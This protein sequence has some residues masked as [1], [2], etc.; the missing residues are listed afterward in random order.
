MPVPESSESSKTALPE[1]A[2]IAEQVHRFGGGVY[3]RHAGFPPNVLGAAWIS[4]RAVALGGSGLPLLDSLLQRWSVSGRQTSSLP[5]LE[6]RRRFA[7]HR[8]NTLALSR[9][10][11]KAHRPEIKHDAASDVRIS[12]STVGANAAISPAA[13]PEPA[14]ADRALEPA[15]GPQGEV[16]TAPSGGEAKTMAAPEMDSSDSGPIARKSE[17]SISRAVAAAPESIGPDTPEG[18]PVHRAADVADAGINAAAADHHMPAQASHELPARREKVKPSEPSTAQMGPPI[19][20]RI[21]TTGQSAALSRD[22]V[23]AIPGRRLLPVQK[24]LPQ[25]SAAPAG[26]AQSSAAPAIEKAS[27]GNP[28]RAVEQQDV[29]RAVSANLEGAPAVAARAVPALRVSRLACAPDITRTKESGVQPPGTAGKMLHRLDQGLTARDEGQSSRMPEQHLAT[30]NLTSTRPS[31]PLAL[32]PHP[33]VARIVSEY[34]PFMSVAGSSSPGLARALPESTRVLPEPE[35]VR[36][37]PARVLRVTGEACA[38]SPGAGTAP[39]QQQPEAFITARLVS[40]TP[41][42]SPGQQAMTPLIVRRQ[43]SAG[44]AAARAGST[45]TAVE[46]VQPTI[47]ARSFLPRFADA[48]SAVA[49]ERHAIQAERSGES[50][51]SS[52]KS[53][54]VVV[55]ASVLNTVREAGHA[56]SDSMPAG[57]TPVHARFVS[58]DVHPVPSFGQGGIEPLLR[59][60]ASDPQSGTAGR[61]VVRESILARAAESGVPAV[62]ALASAGVQVNSHG[63]NSYA[64]R[65]SSAH[66]PAKPVLSAIE[67]AP[68]LS[69]LNLTHRS[70][71]AGGSLFLPPS[72]AAQSVAR[73]VIE[74]QA[75]AGSP[76]GGSNPLPAPAAAGAAFNTAASGQSSM[77]VAQL[78]NR[79]YELIVR[80]LM[81][82]RQRRGR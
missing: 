14:V 4:Q 26:I 69:R 16:R 20:R 62:H 30:S 36:S 72:G 37:E 8:S 33:Q 27:P 64:R 43:A 24:G 11:W 32:E 23:P 56:G 48:A 52:G 2:R 19:F 68:R 54:S 73:A 58:R 61:A 7:D 34:S 35:S 57:L 74:R 39:V 9:V 5:V 31:A 80:R 13:S 40:E 25:A 29:S 18:R 1:D 28:A 6:W 42:A 10:A 47:A 51:G 63:P 49:P 79:V 3:A 66:D 65:Y 70:V 46:S 41:G 12:P 60:A 45:R 55:H 50:G 44:P 59:S 71:T 22:A 82:E 67:A 38:G 21:S 53:G 17:S 78:A 77:D 75:V 76:R 15:P 81:S